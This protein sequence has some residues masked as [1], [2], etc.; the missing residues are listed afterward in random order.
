MN[1]RATYQRIARWYD[2]LDAPFERKRYR[3]FRPLLFVGLTGRIHF[4]TQTGDFARSRAFYRMLGFTAGVGGFPKT[5][6]H[7]MA[8]SLGM[9][10]LCTYEIQEIEVISIP[11]SWGPT[12]IDLIQ[13]AE[14]FNRENAVDILVGGNMTVVGVSNGQIGDIGIV[15]YFS[16]RSVTVGIGDV[17]RFVSDQMDS[18][19]GKQAHST[20]GQGLSKGGPVYSLVADILGTGMPSED[21]GHPILIFLFLCIR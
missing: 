14:P 8:R 11:A 5:N 7:E 10:D 16:E 12:S 13:F 17:E 20:L 18:T 2:L 15:G 19:G 9:Y 1:K 21:S 6:T 4:N 3:P